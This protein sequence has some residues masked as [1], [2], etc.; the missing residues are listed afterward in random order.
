[1]QEVGGLDGSVAVTLGAHQSIGLQGAS[2][3]SGREEQKTK[4]LPRLATGEMMAAFALTEP[5]AGSD[6]AAIHTHAAASPT[7]TLHAQRR[8]DLDHERRLRRPLHRLRAH[9]A[10]RRGR[11]A[12]ASPRSSSSA[13]WASRPVRTSTSSASA[14]ARPPRS[15]STTCVVPASNVLGEVGRGFKVAM[16]VLNSGAPRPRERAASA[17]AST[18]SRWRSER[19][20]ERK[21]FG[22][23]IG[24]FGLVK[25]KIAYDARRDLRAREHGLP[26]DRAGRRAAERLLGRERDLQ[27]V[28][29][30]DALARRQ[31]DAADRRGHRLH[32]GVSV[33]AACSATRAS[34]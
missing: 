27:G 2:C 22:R 20:Q 14:G 19:V 10:A 24:E 30:G 9:L 21:A 11:E 34:T 28:R 7:A 8:E 18:S 5:S 31:R 32:G 6:A 33:R 4:Y 25:D 17:S 13:A 15:S 3:S 12:A 16:E 29:L 23:T 26:H 1:M